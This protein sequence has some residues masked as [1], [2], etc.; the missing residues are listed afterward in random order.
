MMINRSFGPDSIISMLRTNKQIETGTKRQPVRW[1]PF[2]HSAI[3]FKW[4]DF[5]PLF[6]PNMPNCK[7]NYDKQ[8]RRISVWLLSKGIL[9]KKCPSDTHFIDI[10][11]HLLNAQIDKSY[12]FHSSFRKRAVACKSF[13]FVWLF[14]NT[15]GLSTHATVAPKINRVLTRRS[16]SG[17][18]KRAHRAAPPAGQSMRKMRKISQPNKQGISATNKKRNPINIVRQ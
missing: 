4:F 14:T 3:R 11:L 1:N 2:Y 15:R 6:P 8:I 5:I 12:S 13:F 9:M 16:K 18:Q 10:G 7:Q 17:D